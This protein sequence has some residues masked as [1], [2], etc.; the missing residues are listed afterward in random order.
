MSEIVANGQIGALDFQGFSNSDYSKFFAQ[1]QDSCSWSPG[2]AT[3]MDA[4]PF[5]LLLK[6]HWIFLE[7]SMK[8]IWKALET[9]MNLLLKLAWMPFLIFLRHV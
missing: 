9:P 2:W 5:S 1:A 4:S 6:H 3:D 8:Y 7:T